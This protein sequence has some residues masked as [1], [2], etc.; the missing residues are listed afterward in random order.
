ML[1]SARLALSVLALTFGALSASAQTE[2]V[3]NGSMNSS[4]TGSGALPNASGWMNGG[5][6]AGISSSCDI[7][8]HSGIAG[9]VSS[10]DGGTWASCIGFATGSMAGY[11]ESFTGQ[12]QGGG[13]PRLAQ[14]QT[15]VVRFFF[16]NFGG[17]F[18]ATQSGGPGGW[19]VYVD[20]NLVGTTQTVSVSDD[21][22]AASFSFTPSADSYNPIIKF[23]PT[24]GADMRMSVDGISVLLDDGTQLAPV[25]NSGV[26]QTVASGSTVNLGGTAIDFEGDTLSNLSNTMEMYKLIQEDLALYRDN[27]ENYLTVL[28]QKLSK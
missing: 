28:R 2:L 19:R 21:W 10:P 23:A 6:T 16:A 15:Y 22:Y 27:F 8:P 25:I 11:N 1:T 14:G 17:R 13:T 18:N 4:R 20:N 9:S 5:Y 26:D 7:L 3:P 12:L 24:T